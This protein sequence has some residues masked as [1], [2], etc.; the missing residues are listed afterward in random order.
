MLG[1]KKTNIKEC[2]H[3][4]NKK[5]FK[6][7]KDLCDYL[8]LN[9]KV[10]CKSIGIDYCSHQRESYIKDRVCFGKNT[11]RVDFFIKEKNGGYVILEIKNPK[12]LNAEGNQAISQVLSYI[13]IAEK[14]KKKI[15][16]TIILTTN[17]SK[18]M[19]QIIT[20]FNL[21]I[22]VVL[23]SKNYSAICL[24]GGDWID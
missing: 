4:F 3:L 20:R 15:N 18:N 8:E 24:K 12:N 23:F 9:I 11:P 1:F 2:E 5:E 22:E 16:K 14:A 21:P 17:L 13:M 7:E 6:T 19:M 10:F